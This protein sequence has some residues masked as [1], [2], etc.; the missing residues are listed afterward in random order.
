MC[1]LFISVFQDLTVGDVDRIKG[2]S[3]HLRQITQRQREN[4]SMVGKLFSEL[5]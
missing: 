5:R 1:F 2:F 4:I 3:E